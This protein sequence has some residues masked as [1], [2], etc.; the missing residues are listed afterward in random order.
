MAEM[1]TGW[2]DA[3]PLRIPDGLLRPGFKGM[4]GKRGRHDKIA[5]S[6]LNKFRRMEM[7]HDNVRTA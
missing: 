6:F 4:E 3:L 2:M 5:R 1:D 7:E